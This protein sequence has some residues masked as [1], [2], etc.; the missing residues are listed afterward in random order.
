MKIIKLALVV[1]T[2]AFVATSC[3]KDEGKLPSIQFNTS[4]DFVSSDIT[5]PEGDTAVIQI[6]ADKT[7]DKDVLKKFDI[8]LSENGGVNQSIY[9]V[10]LNSD[11]ED[12][13]EYTYRAVAGAGSGH[14]RKY[15][16]T[17]S[18]RDG[19]VNQQSITITTQ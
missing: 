17:I 15:T 14:T 13:F 18:N 2:M 16:F 3:K 12:H 8:S 5:L 1:F 11:Q 19:L 4:A 7:E 6:I 10:D 9:N